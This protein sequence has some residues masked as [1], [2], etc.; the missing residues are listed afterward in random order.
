MPISPYNSKASLIRPEPRPV[1]YAPAMPM[2][3]IFRGSQKAKWSLEANGDDFAFVFRAKT[4]EE[5]EAAPY[6]DPEVLSRTLIDSFLAVND[7]QEALI[8][9]GATGHFLWDAWSEKEP[10]HSNT[11]AWSE[12]Q[13]WQKL[14]S[15]IQV[16]GFLLAHRD[17]QGEILRAPKDFPEW[18]L[19]PETKRLIA[20]VPES[21]IDRLN[22]CQPAF[23]LNCRF[24]PDPRVVAQI[25]SVN[26]RCE[27]ENRAPTPEEKERI[28]NFSASIAGD[29]DD[30]GDYALEIEA[31][32]TIDAMLLR[33]WVEQL[34]EIEYR[35]CKRKGCNKLFERKFKHEKNYC[36]ERCAHH[37]HVAASAKNPNKK[38]K[39]KVAKTRTRKTN[40]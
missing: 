32:T 16:D 1:R 15:H 18:E 39:K 5:F 6:D 11:V 2:E 38:S 17:E 22:G 14:I 20:K 3:V 35:K 4:L 31:L 34:N 33:I 29:S 37:D 8:F 12:F 28:K 24:R 26:K 19:P 13:E 7:P 25:D 30:R 21:T 10:N 9:L 40:G 23:S 27:S 36:S